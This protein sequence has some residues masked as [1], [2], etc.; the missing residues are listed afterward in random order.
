VF[1]LSKPSLS[2]G[3]K[4]IGEIPKCG[5]NEGRLKPPFAGNTGIPL[6]GAR[7]VAGVT[8]WDCDYSPHRKDLGLR[9]LAPSKRFMLRKL[10]SRCGN[11]DTVKTNAVSLNRCRTCTRSGE[12]E[13]YFRSDIICNL[14]SH[15]TFVPPPFLCLNTPL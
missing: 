7:S 10:A 14:Y 2:S 4:G 3:K 13:V 9:L 15:N 5:Y 1:T 11:E 8:S 12:S 6:A